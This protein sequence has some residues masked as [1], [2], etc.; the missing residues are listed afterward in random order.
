MLDATSRPSLL[1]TSTALAAA[2]ILFVETFFLLALSLHDHKHDTQV[3]T[4][5]C[6][7]LFITLL[8]R[9]AY[10]RTLWLADATLAVCV[11]SSTAAFTR[12]VIL[13]FE[14]SSKQALLK[15]PSFT[16]TPEHFASFPSRLFFGWLLPLLRIGS[17]PLMLPLLMPAADHK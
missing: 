4:L 2:A 7:Y 6:L 5:L 14:S 11:L 13:V 3:D 1:T 9:C 15:T 10:V 12:A 8:C 17:F 16:L